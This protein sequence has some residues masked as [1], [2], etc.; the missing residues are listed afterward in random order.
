MIRNA[1]AFAGA[2][3]DS[4]SLAAFMTGLYL[5]TFHITNNLT[6]LS[7]ASMVILVLILTVPVTAGVAFMN[8]FLR[9]FGKGTLG[10]A[11]TV[12]VCA[13]Y[14]LVALRGAVFGTDAIRHFL[15]SRD[16]AG[17]FLA[18]IFYY[19]IPATLLTLLFREHLRKLIIVL[20]AMT[21]ASFAMSLPS[22]MSNLD[23]GGDGYGSEM[24]KKTPGSRREAE[25]RISNSSTIRRR[26][27]ACGRWVTCRKQR[28]VVPGRPETRIKPHRL[29][30]AIDRLVRPP[31]EP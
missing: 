20:G 13:A 11:L 23:D 31:R 29:A 8:A 5:A 2:A 16:D 30:I 21:I 7:V 19:A 12:F 3:A 10:R 9:M 17:S 24:A 18:R 6:M 1:G 26:S 14:M 27:D 25:F 4:P 22:A 15:E 28:Q